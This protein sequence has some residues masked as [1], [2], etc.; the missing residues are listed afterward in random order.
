MVQG[1]FHDT[2]TINFEH[3]FEGR[4]QL[5]L[6]LEIGAG[7]GDWAVERAKVALLLSTSFADYRSPP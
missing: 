7:S 2:G 3:V 5:P 4:E 1:C 6:N